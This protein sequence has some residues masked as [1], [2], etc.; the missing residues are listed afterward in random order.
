MLLNFK[1][2]KRNWWKIQIKISKWKKYIICF[3]LYTGN[4]NYVGFDPE[5]AIGNL[6]NGRYSPL[7]Y[8]HVP[9][10]GNFFFF[11]TSVSKLS[12]S[13]LWSFNF[14]VLISCNFLFVLQE[15]VR[16]RKVSS[17]CQKKKKLN[18]NLKFVFTGTFGTEIYFSCASFINI[19]KEKNKQTN[20][21]REN[22]K[23]QKL[24]SCMEIRN[25][26]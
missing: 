18:E 19:L 11:F 9:N 4:L 25:L 21:R 15:N 13:N 22:V 7:S 2:D 26:T 8:H 5:I 20:K 23:F 14:C 6:S 1:S 17:I 3:F 12:S 24:L 10:W 16:F